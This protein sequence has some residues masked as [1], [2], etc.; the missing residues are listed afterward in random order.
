MRANDYS[1]AIPLSRK[2]DD[3]VLM[4]P[5]E[6]IELVDRN[7]AVPGELLMDVSSNVGVAGGGV[8]GMSFTNERSYQAKGTSGIWTWLVESQ[9]PRPVRV[10]ST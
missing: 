2:I 1:P 3:Q 8:I 7:R 10:I 9:P 6:V 5:P 4:G